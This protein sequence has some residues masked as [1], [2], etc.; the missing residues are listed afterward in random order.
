M[1]PVAA[2]ALEYRAFETEIIA[3]MKGAMDGGR[4]ILG[5]E[6][7][8]FEQE[9]A[10]F[11]GTRFAIGVAS[12]TDAIYVALCAAG[13]GVGDEVIMPAHT[14]VATLVA[15]EQSGATPVL[16]DIESDSFT[17]DPDSVAQRLSP[18][19]KAIIPVH[20]YGHPANLD[21]LNR[22]VA[23]RDIIVLE[24][25]AQAHGAEYRGAKVGSIGT[26]GAFSFYP[27]KNLGALGDGGM[28]VTSD[29]AIYERATRF[30]TYGWSERFISVERGWNSRLDELQAAILRVKLAHLPELIEQRRS[31]AAIYQ[32]ALGNDL[33]GPVE[34]TDCRHAYHLFVVRSSQRD[35]LQSFLAGQGIGTDIHYPMP[36]HTQPAYRGE[37]GEEGDFPISE[38]ACDEVLSLPLYPFLDQG[39]VETVCSALSSYKP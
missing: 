17:I 25:C 11:I 20:L 35:A 19:T 30:R 28:I 9:F 37:L 3:A 5:H 32:E 10:H 6:V 39:S 36:L 27:T 34:A 2:P 14:A 23:G 21:A 13:I 33:Q 26:V 18:R 31:I 15:V 4:Y 16:A 24:D 22:L 38:R 12:G 29:E 1:I 7:E 8:A